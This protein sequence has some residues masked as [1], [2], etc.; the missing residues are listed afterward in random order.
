MVRQLV[1]EDW[2]GEA[3]LE[4]VEHAI[5]VPLEL[6]VSIGS[7]RPIVS[8]LRLVVNSYSLAMAMMIEYLLRYYC[9]LLLD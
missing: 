4:V 1:I 7:Y 2:L 3:A 6:E 5:V 8:Y 9:V